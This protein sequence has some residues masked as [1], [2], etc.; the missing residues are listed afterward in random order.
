MRRVAFT[1][2]ILA[3]MAVAATASAHHPATGATKRA[4]LNSLKAPG[5]VNNGHNCET[6]ALPC[7]RALISG[8][9]WATAQDIGP[10]NNGAGEW[11]YIDHLSHHHWR[12]VGGEGEGF[13]FACRKERLPPS[14]AR[15]LRIACG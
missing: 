8:N 6:R 13:L 2:A 14:I 4:I 3:V 11:L 1:I 10:G 7:W 12:Y 5:A 9:S 15:D